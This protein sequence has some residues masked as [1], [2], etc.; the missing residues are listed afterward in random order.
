MTPLVQS[1][2]IPPLPPDGRTDTREAD[3]ICENWLGDMSKFV[4]QSDHEAEKE[5]PSGRIKF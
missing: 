3:T 1:S 2:N 4:I 5:K